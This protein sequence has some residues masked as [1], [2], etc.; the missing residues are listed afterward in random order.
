MVTGIKFQEQGTLCCE[1]CLMGGQTKQPFNKKGGTRA[2][3]IL[4]LVHSDV[5]G[6]MS[7]KSISGYR[8]FLTFIDDKTR[9]TFVYFLKSKDELVCKFEEFT[10]LVERQTGKRLK[11]LRSDNGKEYV[12]AE[13]KKFMRVKG[14]KHQL[15]VQYTPEQN[16]IAERCNRTLCTKARNM[17]EDAKLERKFWAEAVN[18]AVH[19]KNVS[20]TKA[21]NDMTPEE[22][23]KGNKVDI[24]YL[25]IFGC[26][27]FMHIPDQQRKKWDARSR[28]LIHMGYCEESK[29]YRLI[30]PKDGK[31]YKARNV[32]FLENEMKEESTTEG[33][34]EQSQIEEMYSAS[35]VRVHC[36]GNLYRL[37]QE[38]KLLYKKKQIPNERVYRGQVEC[39][40]QW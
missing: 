24:G 2:K 27:A 16:G 18:T 33:E 4:E 40:S 12:C 19:L 32:V 25:R 26:Q 8:Y 30:D 23:W 3:E 9:K 21:V 17:L 14:I 5:C 37:N 28:K 29:S 31:L 20:P 22:A 36:T 38:L 39:A 13:M 6:A 15:T 10:A 35:C 34:N 7:E 1:S 11:I